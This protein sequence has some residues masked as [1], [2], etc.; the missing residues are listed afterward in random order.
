MSPLSYPTK[1]YI[2]EVFSHFAEGN[3]EAFYAH[4]ADDVDL[5]LMG[6]HA[7]AGRYN[8]A[9]FKSQALAQINDVFDG[10]VKLHVR[11]IIGGEIEEWAVIELA[12]DAKCKN[13][14]P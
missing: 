14:K 3:S 1:A 7:L 9:T 10:S 11:S 8:K 5:T 6:S 2:R 4:V 13:G 12:A